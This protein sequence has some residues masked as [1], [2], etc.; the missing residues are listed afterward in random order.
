MATPGLAW[1][2]VIVGAYVGGD[3]ALGR[4]LTFAPFMSQTGR[5]ALVGLLMLAGVC[6]R[7]VALARLSRRVFAGMA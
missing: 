1:S 7:D 6:A 2:V 5:M 4:I 3:S